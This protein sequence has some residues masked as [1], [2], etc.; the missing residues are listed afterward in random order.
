LTGLSGAQSAPDTLLAELIPVV[1]QLLTRG[2]S[3]TL[4]PI[5]FSMNGE[6]FSANLRIVTDPAA[7]PAAPR[8]FLDPALWLAIA[9]VNAEADVSKALAQTL[10]EQFARQ[11][12]AA[13]GAASG[14]PMPEEQL[15]E[16]AAAQAGLMLVALSGQGFLEDTG[17]TYTA[18][19]EFA[20]G[21]LTVN[22][23]SVPLGL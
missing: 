7:L 14:Q 10:A 19:L 20:S 21:E 22:G 6:P 15:A 3:L 4:D 5:R 17:E 8:N 9:S 16:M 12:L 13:A 11:Q 23:T 18:T 1:E 2:P